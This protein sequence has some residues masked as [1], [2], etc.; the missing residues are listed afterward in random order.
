MQNNLSFEAKDKTL[1]DILFG[2][3]TSIY[4]IPRYQRPYAWEEEQIEEFW[5]D[6]LAENQTYFLG[7]FIFN[8]QYENEGYIEVIDGQQ[9]LLTTTIFIAVLRDILV[10][11]GDHKTAD[12]YQ[13]QNIG[14]ED[15]EGNLSY[16]IEPGDSTKP[17]FE[18]YIQNPENDI[19]TAN[20]KNKEEKRIF[21]NYQHLREKVEKKLA[22]ESTK[23]RKLS[24]IKD[25]KRKSGSLIVIDIK[26]QSE[27]VAYEIFE[28]VNARG[29]ELSVSDLLKN[30]VF[31]KIKEKDN[32]DVAKEMWSEIESNISQS[33]VDLKKFIRY[34]WISKYGFATEKKLYSSIKA[35]ITDWDAFMMDMYSASFHFTAMNVGNAEDFSEFKSGDKIFR[36]IFAIRLMN[37]SQC[38]VLFLS[39]LQNAKKIGFDTHKTF[40]LIEKFT[41]QYNAICKM[42]GN[43]VEKIYSKYAR[44]IY[45]AIADSKTDKQITQ[46]IQKEL[47]S[48]KQELLHELPSREYFLESFKDLSYGNSDKSR[49]LIKYTLEEINNASGT[50]EH[51]I[52]FT[53]VNIEHILPQEPRKWNLSKRTVK[54][55]VNKIGNLTLLS[56]KL[57]STVGN[58]ILSKK[59]T[60]LAKSEIKIT[61][62]LVN[63][64][65][66]TN[67]WGKEEIERRQQ[68]LATISYDAIWKIT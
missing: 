42:P 33:G 28:T 52:D 36:S 39:L 2:T 26:L 47:S 23:E 15:E 67:H 12:V 27:D 58:D 3:L 22:Q 32:K 34:Y 7:S 60:E 50:G 25:L 57:N 49:M 17:F 11:L 44:S 41:Y 65:K 48:L 16:R 61:S 35:E 37:V 68:E 54:D 62:D 20:P 51:K 38:H 8:T 19:N 64:I 59:I 1:R 14:F 56:K 5:N 18:Y 10:E 21:N 46:N 6:M 66:A 30:L 13:R 45:K 53:K 4:R 40:Q 24:T 9:R 29:V 63:E 55:Y 31:S 43:R